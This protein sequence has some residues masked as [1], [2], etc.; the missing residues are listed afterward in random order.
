MVKFLIPKKSKP[1]EPVAEEPT[2]NLTPTELRS[3]ADALFKQAQQLRK[4]AD[5]IDPPKS[6][7][8]SV[9]VEVE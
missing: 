7:K 9:A 4:K 1:L 6:K 8:K 5:E 2:A 3:R